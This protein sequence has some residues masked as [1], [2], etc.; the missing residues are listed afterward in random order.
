MLGLGFGAAPGAGRFPAGGVFVL[1]V[2]VLEAPLV[3][4]CLVGDLVGD[5]IPLASLGPG[6]GLPAST[7]ALLPGPSAAPA[8]FNPL[9]AVCT[10]LG[11]LFPA[12]L[13]LALGFTSS[14]TCRTPAG[15]R[16]M[17]YPCSHSKYRSP[18]TVPSFFPVGS[19]SSTPTQSPG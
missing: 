13:G 9:T 15:L 2:D 1:D 12:T 18:L 19:S 14:T 3:P 10:L 7:L 16:N 8:L 17:P 5:R 11:L 6:V 4:N